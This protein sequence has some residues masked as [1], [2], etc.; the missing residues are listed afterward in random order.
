MHITSSRLCTPVQFKSNIQPVCL[1]SPSFD[2]STQAVFTVIGWGSEQEGGGAV[3]ALREV[4][5]AN[6]IELLNTLDDG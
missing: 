5:L 6:T 3:A 4:L 1:P 2:P